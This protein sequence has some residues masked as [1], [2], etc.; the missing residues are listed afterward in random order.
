MLDREHKTNKYV[1]QQVNILAGHQELLLST[2]NSYHG[3]AMSA[4]MIRCQKSYHRER[5][6]VV[7]ADKTAR[8]NTKEWTSQSLSS[9]LHIADDR[10]VSNWLYYGA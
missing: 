10:Q 5:W 9:L 2:V 6:K 7:V 4:V 8:E 1:W 3:L